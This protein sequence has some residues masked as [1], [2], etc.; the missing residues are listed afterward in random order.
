MDQRIPFPASGRVDRYDTPLFNTGSQVV[1][2][3]ELKHILSDYIERN[4]EKLNESV[5]L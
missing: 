4:G 1:E 5:P 3:F 2:D